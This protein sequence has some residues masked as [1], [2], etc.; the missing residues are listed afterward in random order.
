MA[1]KGEFFLLKSDPVSC[2]AANILKQQMLSAGGE[3]AVTKDA[4]TCSVDRAPV[5]L[6]GTK[7][8]LQRLIGGLKYQ[9]FGLKEL[10]QELIDFFNQYNQPHS[11]KLGSATFDFSQKTYVMGIL[12]VTPDSF[13]DGGQF[14]NVEQARKAA[15]K[16]IAEGADI[17]DIGGESTRPG[18]DPVALEEELDRV[19]PVI[20]A[21][22]KESD[23]PLSIDTYKSAVAAAALEAGVNAVN[24][25]S[26]LRFDSQMAATIKKYDA[27]V[28]LMHIQGTPR[29]MQQNPHYQNLID[30][31]L[32]HL[33]DSVRMAL[34]AGIAR[35]KITID[36]GIGFGKTVA[37][38]YAILRYLGEF[39]SL[40]LPLLV[41][42]SRKSMIGKL[43]KLPVD[44][45]LEGSLAAMSCA[46]QNGVDMVRVHDVRESVR[47]V[48]VVDTIV[49]KNAK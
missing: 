39:R 5:I 1:P 47:A 14:T 40:R 33:Q 46:I 44:Q 49:G 24:D 2:P 30:E 9:C 37:H 36:P 8:Q 27:A 48:R 7:K 21:I 19:V 34:N 10:R 42:I 31:I 41:S 16:M 29:N 3:C 43:L 23:I 26:G 32:H 12:N 4:T 22:R 38:N 18:A 13:S 20:E 6:I 25:I 28:V 45:R 11:L 17:I 35:N 15:L